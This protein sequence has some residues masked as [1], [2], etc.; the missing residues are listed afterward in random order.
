MGPC[1]RLFL[2]P[3]QTDGEMMAIRHLPALVSALLITLGPFAVTVTLG[4]EGS[5]VPQ[6]AGR[7]PLSLHGP[8]MPFTVLGAASAFRWIRQFGT[9]APDEANAL[10]VDASRVYV[11]GITGN[12]PG[13]FLRKYDLEGNVL[14]SQFGSGGDIYAEAV[15]VDGSGVYVA[16]YMRFPEDPGFNADAFL[17]KYD[18]DGNIVWNRTFGTPEIDHASAVVLDA[19]GIYV[20]GLTFGTF[21]GQTGAGTDAY[22]RKYAR[23]GNVVWTRQFGTSGTDGAAALAVNASGLYVAGWA[24]GTFPGEPTFTGIQD[25]F[26]RKYDL[27]GNV[28]WTHQFEISEVAAANAVAVSQSGVYVAGVVGVDAFVRKYDPDGNVMWTRQFGTTGGGGYAWAL[29]VFGSSVYVIGSTRGGTFPGEESGGGDDAFVR[30]YDTAGKELW[31]HQF[32]TSGSDMA[33]GAAADASSVYV[34]GV[35]D[36]TFPVQTSAGSADA[37][38]AS[39]DTLPPTVLITSPQ[40]G[41]TVGPATVSVTGIASDDVAVGS[42]EVSADGTTWVLATGTTSWSANLTVRERSNTITARATDTTRNVGTTS[43]TVMMQSEPPQRELLPL[44]V[45]VAGVSSLVLA[46]IAALFILRRRKRHGV[47][48]PEAPPPDK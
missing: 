43:V 42:V 46:V 11:A 31:T 34:A 22:V 20:G 9:S 24:E 4:R 15:A 32:G 3:V 17:W 47:H 38:L 36:G 33:R 35:T 45:L 37:F 21:P 28:A 1:D 25:A 6:T 2:V 5:M 10:A 12:S 48:P 8:S 30:R 23:D 40:N 41:T 27:N 13:V 16:G 14:W 44:I 18:L 39:V 29:A 26:L 19:S 7:L